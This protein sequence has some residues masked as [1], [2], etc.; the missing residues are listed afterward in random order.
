MTRP[1]AL[2][3]IRDAFTPAELTLGLTTAALFLLVVAVVAV[4][5]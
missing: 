2:E 5:L 1:E 4:T 3:L